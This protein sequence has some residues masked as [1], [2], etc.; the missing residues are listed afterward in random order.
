MALAN[1]L[2][3]PLDMLDRIFLTVAVVSLTF[4]GV[5]AWLI[6]EKIGE[7]KCQIQS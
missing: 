1:L 3:R 4:S 5:C 7:T 2:G 6:I